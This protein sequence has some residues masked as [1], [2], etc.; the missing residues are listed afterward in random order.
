ME[1]F[2]YC[3]T[4]IGTNK[5][6]I[7]VHKGTPDD[8]YVCSSKPMMEEY[9]NRP[10]DFSRQNVTSGSFKEMYVLETAILK[11]AGADKDPGYYNQALNTGP[12]YHKGSHRD[13]SR[14]KMSVAAKASWTLE[15]KTK[16]SAEQTGKTHTPESRAAR[17]IAMN[18]KNRGTRSPETRAKISVALI[19]SIPWN[20][21]KST[22]PV[23]PQSKIVCPYCQKIGGPGS[24]KRWHFD[25]CKKVKV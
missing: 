3:W 17:R 13:E 1:A 19:G 4:D 9:T 8:G 20:K 11:A 5:L 6:Y 10:N 21:G 18:G 22:G 14:L 23:G 12:F 2:V 25:R 24:M 16:K 15:R 7:G